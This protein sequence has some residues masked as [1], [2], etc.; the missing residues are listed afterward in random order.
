MILCKTT[1]EISKKIYHRIVSLKKLNVFYY[2][3]QILF[4]KK[5][6]DALLKFWQEEKVTL[7]LLQEP[8]GT[9]FSIQDNLW[10]VAMS[11]LHIIQRQRTIRY[12]IYAIK[13]L[14]YFMFVVPTASPHIA[15]CIYLLNLT[16]VLRLT[17][18]TCFFLPSLPTFYPL[19]LHRSARCFPELSENKTLR[20]MAWRETE[21][22]RKRRV[23]KGMRTERTIVTELMQCES[24]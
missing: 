9:C 22:K 8:C 12:C 24:T 20:S 1:L 15:P 4:V 3:K 2:T 11:K 6:D 23:V 5:S 21:I 18:C 10:I 7:S 19:L 14:G 16:P 13:S 17:S